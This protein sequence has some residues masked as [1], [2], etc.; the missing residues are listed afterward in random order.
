MK[1]IISSNIDFYSITTSALVDSLLNADILA[2]DILV[3]I[4]RSSDDFVQTKNDV[5]YHFNTFDAFEYN[6]V[7]S[8]KHL[9]IASSFFLMHDTCLVGPSFG[10]L[11]R[12]KMDLYGMKSVI[13]LRS[14]T[15]GVYANSMGYYPVEYIDIITEQISYI[16]SMP[17]SLEKKHEV[18]KYE[19]RWFTSQNT[20]QTFCTTETSINSGTLTN[21]IG[22][23]FPELDFKKFQANH[24]HSGVRIEL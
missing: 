5:T 9:Q 4:G 14:A 6:A 8:L 24:A 12:S 22:R 13:A 2:S 20:Y 10:K 16:N 18:M 11:L 15:G 3:S 19:D 7:F 17:Y 23:Y 21:R 1:I